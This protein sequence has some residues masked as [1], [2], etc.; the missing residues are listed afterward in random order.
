MKPA[1]PVI[2]VFVT[3]GDGSHG[4]GTTLAC[5]KTPMSGK[6]IVAKMPAETSDN[7]LSMRSKCN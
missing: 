7:P 1:E 2:R 4:P 3:G 6:E 5:G